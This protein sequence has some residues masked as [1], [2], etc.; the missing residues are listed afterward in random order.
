MNADTS[1]HRGKISTTSL[2]TIILV[3]SGEI[4]KQLISYPYPSTR[5]YSPEYMETLN[6]GNTF[7]KRYLVIYWYVS[8]SIDSMLLNRLCRLHHKVV[9]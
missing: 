2:D 5:L 6:D 3:R 4:S 1:V 7:R 9:L 8:G